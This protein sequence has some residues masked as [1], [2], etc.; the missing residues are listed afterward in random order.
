MCL[1]QQYLCNSTPVLAALLPHLAP[2]LPAPDLHRLSLVTYLARRT[3]KPYTLKLDTKPRCTLDLGS[4]GVVR[5]KNTNINKSIDFITLLWN[6][7]AY[8]AKD[9]V[10]IESV[11]DFSEIPKAICE[12][13]AADALSPGKY[14]ECHIFL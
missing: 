10:H 4:V 6:F 14:S 11:G 1:H 3:K 2:N 8:T 7:V 9:K 5:K 13:I 12:S